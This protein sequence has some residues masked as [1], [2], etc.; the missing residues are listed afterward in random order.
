[1]KTGIPESARKEIVQGLSVLLASMYTLYLKTQNFHWN[2]TGPYFQ[3]LHTMFET[4]YNDLFMANDQVAERI[5]ALN[6]FV[7]ASF[8]QFKDLSFVH[9]QKEVVKAESM[10]K[11]LLE[12]HEKI[13]AF[14]RDLIETAAEARDEATN[15]VLTERIDIHEKTAW[16]LRSFLG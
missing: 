14:L 12:D 5:R 13:T 4:Q 1:M 9:D 11:E 15:D 8:S 7:P 6:A 16:M 3:Q 10:V 2:V